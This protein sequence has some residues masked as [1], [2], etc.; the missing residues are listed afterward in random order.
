MKKILLFTLFIFL[1]VL[2]C[3]KK[4][5]P[6]GFNSDFEMKTKTLNWNYFDRIYSYEDSIRNSD[7]S[8]LLLGNFN[9]VR[10]DILMKFKTFPDSVYEVDNSQIKMVINKRLN[11]DTINQDDIKFGLLQ[12]NWKETK[13]T[14]FTTG[15]T[16]EWKNNESFSEQD[17]SEIQNINFTANEDTLIFDFDNQ[18][19][20][21]W[22]NSD[23]LNYGL[24]IYTEKDSAFLEINSS[25]IGDEEFEPTLS[26]DYKIT[27][28]DTVLHYTKKAYNDVFI[29]HKAN[30]EN[31]DYFNSRIIIK[32][33]FPTSSY[34]HFNLPDSIF[35]NDDQSGINDE[36]DL[37]RITVLRSELLLHYKDENQYPLDGSIDVKP[38]LVVSDSAIGQNPTLPLEYSK[39]YIPYGK[40]STDSLNSGEFK[41]DVTSVVQAIISKNYVNS[42]QQNDY[43]NSG[44]VLKTLKENIS[45][46]GSEFYGTDCNDVDK[47]PKLIIKY[48]AP[49]F[50]F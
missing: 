39:D 42:G 2:G 6:T 31:L 20:K 11:F 8:Y 19:V 35:L 21:N 4:K 36:Y 44:L 10:S 50:D 32:G 41:I 9:N 22:I 24:V 38:Y 29:Y 46:E 26:F 43:T 13:V 49:K 23:S 40:T 3:T 48:L 1:L 15:D 18:I 27:E 37:R 16:V 30:D 12:T 28:Q 47:R 33:I 7:F 34:I 25:E 14:W 17:Y 5:N 45:F